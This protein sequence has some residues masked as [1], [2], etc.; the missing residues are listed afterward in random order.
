MGSMVDTN[1]E[2]KEEALSKDVGEEVSPL[3]TPGDADENK[4]TLAI[5]EL[6]G[7]S[8]FAFTNG[9]LLSTYPIATLPVEASRMN[10][11]YK[12]IILG[13]LLGIAGLAQLSAPVGGLYSDKCSHSFGKRRPY[14]AA[15]AVVGG[16]GLVFQWIGSVN[17]IWPLYFVAFFFSMLALNVTFA[18]MMGLIPD[19]VLPEQVGAA[20]GIVAMMSTAG[21]LTGFAA[22]YLV[23]SNTG[24]M[25]CVYLTFLLLSILSTLVCARE[26]QLPEVSQPTWA[27]IKASFYISSNEHHDFFVV[28]VS[29]TF[30]YMGISVM[31]FFTY[32]LEDMIDVK[33]PDSVLAFAAVIGL[34]CGL[35]TTYPAGLLSDYL[36]NGRK[37]YIYVACCMMASGSVGMIF[38][39]TLPPVWVIL[40]L[41]GAFNGVYLTMDYA[42]AIDT[43][44]NQEEAARFLG[45]WGVAA[46]IGSALGP[47]VGGPVLYFAGDATAA[48]EFSRWG[49]GILFV[50]SALYLLMSSFLLRYV[51]NV[52]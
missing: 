52:K 22:W 25:Y 37:I 50:L 40:G 48:G 49:Y 35:M 43:L 23:D 5:D 42:I 51:E 6:M 9:C 13:C 19:L 33:D 26:R 38:C 7:I 20:N 41:N 4:R 8:S 28:F 46:F 30:Y 18:A 2:S 39:S 32:Y 47:V 27:D 17:T 10:E 3:I 12:S 45:L 1:E 24:S 34:A 21:A 36:Q 29:R 15:G 16:V 11:E 44:P 14:M 31:T